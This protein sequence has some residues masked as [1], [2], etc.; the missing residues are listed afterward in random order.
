[1][2][3]A[4]CAPT[5]AVARLSALTAVRRPAVAPRAAPRPSL[6]SVDRLASSFTGAWRLQQISRGRR[7][8][9]VWECSSRLPRGRA[10]E[11]PQR[12]WAPTCLDFMC[13][14]TRWQ[15][16]KCNP[17]SPC[18][19][20][21]GGRRGEGKQ[22]PAPA[23]ASLSSQGLDLVAVPGRAC[24]LPRPR[25]SRDIAW[26]CMH[27]ACVALPACAP[28]R[29]RT[30]A[31]LPSRIGA[32]LPHALT[33]A[34]TLTPPSPS[35]SHPPH[36]GLTLAPARRPGTA[37]SAPSRAPLTVVANSR[38]SMGCTK[39]GTRRRA[40]RTSGFRARMATP[41]GRAIIRARRKKGRK[42][43]CTKSLYRK[44]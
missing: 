34:H 22:P 10:T 44:P 14:A 35:P 37:T 40:T 31:P 18:P 21:E 42:V 36:A 6:S 38:T 33:L 12:Q 11:V 24:C 4:R 7:P 23:P 1:M 5:P 15:C 25:L 2:L 3:R 17:V 20:R 13:L 19:L 8:A 28:P 43:L 39:R 29:A 27:T 32:G 26:R 41:S 9:G 30:H 16:K